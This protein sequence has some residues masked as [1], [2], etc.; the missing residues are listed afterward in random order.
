MLC[1]N[2]NYVTKYT[3]IQEYELRKKGKK[4][5]RKKAVAG[6]SL[7]LKGTKYHSH[8]FPLYHRRFMQKTCFR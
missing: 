5:L 6:M 3:Q 2:W 4:R 8:V 7:R 1:H